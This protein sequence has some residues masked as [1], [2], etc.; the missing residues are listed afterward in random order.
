MTNHLIRLYAAAGA[1]IAFFLA[2][3]GIAAR[4]WVEQPRDP[5]LVALEQREQRLQ[6][7]AALVQQVVDR[8]WAAYRAALA[9]SRTQVAAATATAPSVRV[10]TLPPIAT[11]RSS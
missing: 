10:V 8:R 11:T 9:L 6:R 5:H 2:W 3:A 1:L 7:D 4:P